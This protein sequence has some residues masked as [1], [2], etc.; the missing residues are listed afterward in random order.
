[1]NDEQEQEKVTSKLIPITPEM[2]KYVWNEYLEGLKF[3]RA[4]YPDD[5]KDTP[6][7]PKMPSDFDE[8]CRLRNS[9]Y[10]Y[11]DSCYS[12]TYW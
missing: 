9:L 10:K 12:D 8:I 2:E 1:M 11:M 4:K 7:E 5:F 6:L 3:Y